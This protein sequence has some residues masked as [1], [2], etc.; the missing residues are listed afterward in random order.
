ML[1]CLLRIAW[2]MLLPKAVLAAKL[3]ASENRLVACVDAAN[4]R[5]APGPRFA[6]TARSA[7]MFL[8][9]LHS[10]RASSMSIGHLEGL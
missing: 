10:I 8:R 1:G 5:K 9:H 7:L 2:L 6:Q 4:R 3:L